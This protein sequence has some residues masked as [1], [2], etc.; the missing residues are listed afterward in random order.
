MTTSP[1]K[2]AQIV[3]VLL[4]L[5]MLTLSVTADRDDKAWTFVTTQV[6]GWVGK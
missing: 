2:A 4:L 3:A 6:K 5:T 1:S